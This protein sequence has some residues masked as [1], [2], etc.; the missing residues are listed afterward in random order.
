MLRRQPLRHLSVDE[1]KG[2]DRAVHRT[3]G[4][5]RRLRTAVEFEDLL[6]S[7]HAATIRATRRY[8]SVTASCTCEKRA[9][10]DPVRFGVIVSRRHAHRAVDRTLIKRVLREACRHHADAFEQFAVHAAVQIRLALRLKSPLV[11]AHGQALPM[12]RW[13]RTLRTEADS[14]LGD[15]LAQLP[16]RT[17]SA[18]SNLE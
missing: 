15:A 4:P 7:P 6:R 13:R 2:D 17:L 11:D 18:A 3:L 14:L 10:G 12:R 16:T 1:R 8:L 9:L 5:E